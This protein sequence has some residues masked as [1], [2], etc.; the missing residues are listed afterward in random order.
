MGFAI[1]YITV[2]LSTYI[3]S[4]P[5]NLPQSGEH[6]FYYVFPTIFLAFEIEY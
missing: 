2:E 4:R 6:Y 1:Y 5:S 3:S